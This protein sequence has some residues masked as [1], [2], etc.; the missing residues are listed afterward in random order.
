MGSI[1]SAVTELTSLVNTVRT[2]ANVIENP[3]SLNPFNTQSDLL[4][5]RQAETLKELQEKQQVEDRRAQA[6]A[7]LQKAQLAAES[8]VSRD[9]TQAAL[10][11][12]VAKQ[13]AQF[14]AEGISPEEGSAQ[15]VLLGLY[16]QNDQ[17]LADQQRI[18]NLRNAAI[19]QNLNDQ[20]ALDVLQRTQL[21]QRQKL[22]RIA[23]NY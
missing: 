11:R 12:A 14:G 18:E 17:Q 2:V 15:A 19:D 9:Q 4:A 6:E 16:K 20:Y 1:L 22:D 3:A 13:R 5:K 7:S 23:E 8:Q 21:A 10:M